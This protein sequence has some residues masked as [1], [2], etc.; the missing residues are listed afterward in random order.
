M[1]EK[2]LIKTISGECVEIVTA[3]LIDNG[4]AGMEIVDAAER[5]KDLK[6]IIGS[7]DYAE[8]SLLT[9][10]TDEIYVVFY[11]ETCDGCEETLYKIESE[12]KQFGEIELRREKTDGSEWLN[13][14]KKYFK[15]IK[16]KDVVIVPVWEDYEAKN[17]ETV[18][19]IDPGAAFGTGQH[20]STM[21]CVHALQE[22]VKKDNIVLDIGCGSGILACISSLIGAKKVVACDIDPIGAISATMI[23]AELNG[24]SNIEVL[25]GDASS[26]L[27]C[28]ISK[29][30]YDVVVANIA[31]DVIMEL[32]P[33]VKGILKQGG[34]FISSGIISEKAAD[35]SRAF[36]KDELE[37]VWSKDIND[38]YAFV[39]QKNA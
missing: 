18:F 34:K 2:I 24:I 6:S 38:W 10:N 20:E 14:W 8:E 25:S 31:A 29:I 17:H 16:I 36:H 35:V 21:L 7:W 22:F 12:L 37:T 32:V 19:K 33:F 1:W 28:K 13:E 5:V 30:K 11:I 39:V 3:V 15:P 27:A 9:I 23:N 26:D 4:I